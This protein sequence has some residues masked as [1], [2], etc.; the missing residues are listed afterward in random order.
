MTP[1]TT[2]KRD[3]SHENKNKL[4]ERRTSLEAKWTALIFKTALKTQRLMKNRNFKK[5]KQQK[6]LQT[7]TRPELHKMTQLTT[8]PSSFLFHGNV[9]CWGNMVAFFYRCLHSAPYHSLRWWHTDCSELWSFSALVEVFSI[10]KT[11]LTPHLSPF[12]LTLPADR[13]F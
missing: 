9:C 3:K 1:P 11:S 12:L 5:K 2:K 13:P 7:H 8:M 6:H 10:Q 4:K